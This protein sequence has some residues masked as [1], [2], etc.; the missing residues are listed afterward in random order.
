MNYGFRQHCALTHAYLSEVKAALPW[1]EVRLSG[2]EHAHCTHAQPSPSEAAEVGVSQGLAVDVPGVSEG[3]EGV[4]DMMRAHAPA[5]NH[6]P[7]SKPATKGEHRQPGYWSRYT[8]VTSKVFL[9]AGS[10][11]SGMPPCS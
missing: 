4:G 11:F 1:R 2:E 10:E 3:E 9:K 7:T 5:R 8:A 6:C